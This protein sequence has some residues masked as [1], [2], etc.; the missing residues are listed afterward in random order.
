M[1][2]I[3]I[4]CRKKQHWGCKV[5]DW[6]QEHIVIDWTNGTLDDRKLQAGGREYEGSVKYA[7]LSSHDFDSSKPM[8]LF[9]RWVCFLSSLTEAIAMA[10]PSTPGLKSKVSGGLFSSVCVLVWVT[11]H[12]QQVLGCSSY[13]HFVISWSSIAFNSPFFQRF[14]M[15]SSSLPLPPEGTCFR[16]TIPSSTAFLSTTHSAAQMLEILLQALPMGG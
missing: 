13:L 7:N 11:K 10:E 9:L 1:I 6:N 16:M 8:R 14:Q 3:V 4:L 12:A 5:R 15:I 2:Y